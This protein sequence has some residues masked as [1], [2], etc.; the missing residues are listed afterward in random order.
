MSLQGGCGCEP[1]EIF[2]LADQTLTP[3]RE[4]MVRSHLQQCPECYDLYKRE[5]QLNSCLESLSFFEPRSVRTK[6][7]IALPTRPLKARLLWASLAG[8]L[9][10]AAL[11][12]LFV[13]GAN[14]VVFVVD[15]MTVFWGS[16]SV[17]ADMLD[18]VLAVAGGTLLVVLAVGAFLDLLLAAVLVSV[19]RRRTRQTRQV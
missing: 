17:L 14:P 3:E 19:N 9:L 18:T 11:F 7:A 6:V 15:A 8:V 12:A 2:E 13:S 10:S 5:R 1:E 4:R 16:A